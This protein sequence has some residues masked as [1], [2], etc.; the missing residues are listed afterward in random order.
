MKK[1]L[2]TPIEA[3]HFSNPAL[4]LATKGVDQKK[5][6]RRKSSK[7]TQKQIITTTPSHDEQVAPVGRWGG[8]GCPAAISHPHPR[9]PNILG[10]M[11]KEG[12]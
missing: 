3:I 9:L 6:E 7:G 8:G 5:L 4:M 12:K 10:K 1:I 11:E 2:A